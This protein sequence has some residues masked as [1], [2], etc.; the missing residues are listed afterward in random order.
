MTRAVVRLR[1]VVFAF[2]LV[3]AAPADRLGRAAGVAP[4]P[5]VGVEMPAAGDDGA[6][7]LAV[8]AAVRLGLGA[9]RV[10][11]RDSAN[12]GFQNPH[13]DE[14]SDNDVDR[15]RAPAIV[16]AFAADPR[17]VAAAGGLR[18]NV[19][20]AD[21]A[22]AE[23]LGLPV[24]VLARWSRTT[25]RTAFCLCASPPRLVRFGRAVARDR[26]GRHVLLVLVGI[27]RTLP[28]LWPNGFAGTPV[29]RVSSPAEADAARRRALNADAVLVIADE[30]PATLWRGSAFRRRFDSEY[31]TR[32]GHR[33]FVAVPGGTAS[34]EV[35]VLREVLPDGAARRAFVR[36]FRAAAGF[37]PGDEAVR[38]Y[39]AAQILRAAGSDRAAVRRALRQRTFD[40]AAGPVVFD[41][42]GYRANAAFTAR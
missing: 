10:V 22:A 37:V 23:R 34:G 36:R 12:G 31:L 42:D 24:I 16:G 26:F 40:T 14:G 15:Q 27:A 2:A 17:I 11:A 35:V 25:S 39:A 29:A 18:R 28:A 38:G 3:A 20:D 13:R 4:A 30:R 21:A 19:G 9:G 6:V 33:D 7:G 41:S 1:A 5:L 32:L 8:L